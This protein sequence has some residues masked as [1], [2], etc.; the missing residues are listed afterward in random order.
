MLLSSRTDAY[1][2]HVVLDVRYQPPRHEGGEGSLA[3][4]GLRRLF[5]K[6]PGCLGVTWDGLFRGVHRAAIA[7]K[8]HLAI[9]KQQA[10]STPAASTPYTTDKCHHDLWTTER[11]RVT[12]RH[13]TDGG[14]TTPRPPAD[15]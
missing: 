6:A 11:G 13:I 2:S 7:D 9:N 10:P 8:G 14:T 1:T 12:E 15:P 5:G 3:L 4:T